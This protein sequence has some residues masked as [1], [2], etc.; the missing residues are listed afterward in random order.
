M[1]LESRMSKVKRV[2]VCVLSACTY[3]SH[4]FMKL[5]VNPYVI[6]FRFRFIQ[7]VRARDAVPKDS[8]DA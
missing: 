3:E 6:E 8:C 1:F 4:A 7:H 5:Q 2:E